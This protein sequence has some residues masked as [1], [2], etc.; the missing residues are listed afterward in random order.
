MTGTDVIVVG[1]GVIG[2]AIAWRAAQAGLRAAVVDPAPGSGASWT[3]AGMLAP[4]TELYYGE[5][6]LYGL[7]RASADLYPDF[8]AELEAL[9]GQSVGYRASGTL[10]TAWDAADLASLSDLHTFHSAL[11]I[12]TSM[13]TGR[14]L[15]R[16]EPATAPGLPGALF[17]PDDHQVDNRL[18][19]AALLAA[20]R[21]AGVE[22][23]AA[24]ASV[25]VAG[26]RAVGVTL[27]NG[28]ERSADA[29]VLAGGAWSRRIGGVPEGLLPPV[30]PVKGQT[31]RVRVV[32]DP[33]LTRTVRA[34]VRGNAVYVVP[35]ADG[36]LVI[37]ASSEET[38]F[39]V[40]PRV[41][42]IHD[43]L[44]DAIAVVPEL[45]E[46]H[47]ES[48]ST[49]LR[50]G[51]PDN[52]PLIGVTEMEGLI[53]ATG[54]YRNGILLTPITAEAVA[55]LLTG[56]AVPAAVRAFVPSRFAPPVRMTQEAQR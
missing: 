51:T 30:R 44:R 36:E 49:S 9:T 46:A 31:L 45:A 17:A 47:W 42:A 20:V 10:L 25:R 1:A 13:V 39:G 34:K 26:G 35:R 38:G 15:R 14:E 55:A 32:G 50:P 12:S 43:L 53:V 2:L 37:G 11:G 4:A 27:D 18:L 21:G 40:Q 19:H 48:V 52:G 23:V 7:N 56:G 33:P 41:G 29:L 28:Q 16:L 8:A 24:Q 6:E 3:A 5:H 54:H 22:V